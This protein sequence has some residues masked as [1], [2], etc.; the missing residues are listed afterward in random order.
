M[1]WQAPAR[2][3]RTILAKASWYAVTRSSEPSKVAW[4]NPSVP[5]IPARVFNYPTMFAPDPVFPPNPTGLTS[6]LPDPVE[7]NL[8]YASYATFALR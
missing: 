5:P 2:S 7:R 6:V 4:P 1:T 3:Q 8:A